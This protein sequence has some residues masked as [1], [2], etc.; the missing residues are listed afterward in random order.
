MFC[1]MEIIFVF[2]YIYDVQNGTVYVCMQFFVQIYNKYVHGSIYFW[3]CWSRPN[4]DCNWHQME[5]R[6]F[7]KQLENDNYNQIRF[8]LTWFGN[9]FDC[10]L[11]CNC[12][13]TINLSRYWIGLLHYFHHALWWCR[14]TP[15]S[16]IV[17]RLIA[18]VFSVWLCFLHLFL[19]SIANSLIAQLDR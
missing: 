5:L 14:G 4:L 9:Q 3:I 11:I 18:V 8:D 19:H 1:G 15:V 6:L 16:R 17:I 13:T 7:S 10:V 2:I 12:D